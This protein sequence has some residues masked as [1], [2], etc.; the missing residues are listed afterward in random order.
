LSVVLS[1]LFLDGL[2]EEDRA[3]ACAASAEERALLELD[4]GALLARAKAAHPEVAL[5]DAAFL[6]FLARKIAPDAEVRAALAELR[7]E[8]L[9]L[10][11]A[12]SH[13]DPAALRV[14]ERAYL[15]RLD[16]ALARAGATG[17]KL[18]EVKQ[19]LRERLFL[20]HGEDAPR[21]AEF[22]GKGDLERWLRAVAVRLAVDLFRS[23]EPVGA[24]DDE[25]GGLAIDADDPELANLKS[26][27]REEAANAMRT[28][29]ARLD[30]EARG[31]LRLYYLEG[32]NLE[33]LAK[34][35]GVA[36]STMSRRLR[37]AKDQVL[38]ETRKA[39]AAALA[40]APGEV[41][42]ILELVQSR[43][44]VSRRWLRTDR[45]GD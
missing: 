13:G 12:A 44:D 1:D 43:L 31:D 27:Y 37:T 28:A 7:A 10:A 45:S 5:A 29:F 26:Q 17:D 15:P 22:G 25:L 41:D 2:A 35:R 6:A 3:R 11:C 39:L 9:Y 21:I 23:G 19:R 18:A 20:R 14:F 4:L 33:R 24:R 16:G 8:G 38:R 40:M 30:A 32:L 42:S 36:I 34:L